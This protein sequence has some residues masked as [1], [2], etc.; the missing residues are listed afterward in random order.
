ML[1]QL[2]DVS[3]QRELIAQQDLEL[4]KHG[5]FR[6]WI[7]EIM[8]GDEF[9]TKSMKLEIVLETSPNFIGEF[10]IIKLWVAR[11]YNNLGENS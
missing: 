8:D 2:H 1:V 5:L 4:V 11:W 10:D 6:K 3:G 9:I 7:H